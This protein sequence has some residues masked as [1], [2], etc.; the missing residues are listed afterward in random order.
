VPVSVNPSVE[1]VWR[2]LVRITA[3][4]REIESVCTETPTTG[5][6]RAGASATGGRFAQAPR[7]GRAAASGVTDLTPAVGTKP[8]SGRARGR[9][10]TR[11]YATRGVLRGSGAAS[12]AAAL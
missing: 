5:H 1:D 8:R 10:R 11:V 6:A 4:W 7:Q 9:C 12:S 3:G 2:S